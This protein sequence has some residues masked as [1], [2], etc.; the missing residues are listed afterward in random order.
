[1]RRI[2]A[3]H[4]NVER[5][6]LASNPD[7]FDLFVTDRAIPT[8]IATAMIPPRPLRWLADELATIVTDPTH[9]S[10]TSVGRPLHSG[11]PTQFPKP[12]NGA[13]AREKNGFLVAPI[14]GPLAGVSVRGRTTIG[15]TDQR[16]FLIALAA[17]GLSLQHI[18]GD[19]AI[20]SLQK[21]GLELASMG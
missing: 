16:E 12:I 14:D 11:A 15:V 19:S 1:M 10:Y 13:W 6:D 2:L 7:G 21:A 9:R 17:M 3:A 8:N 20:E 5:A 4:P 18:T